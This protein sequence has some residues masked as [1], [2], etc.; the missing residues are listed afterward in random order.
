MEAPV[1]AAQVLVELGDVPAGCPAAPPAQPIADSWAGEERR[2][3]N[4]VW[5]LRFVV[6]RTGNVPPP[7]YVQG[8]SPFTRWRPYGLRA[9]TSS[10]VVP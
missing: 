1:P 7:V 10:A 5:V 3:A 8:W 9:V 2:P 4:G 6:A